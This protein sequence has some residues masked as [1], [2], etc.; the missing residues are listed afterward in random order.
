MDRAKKNMTLAVEQVF[1]LLNSASS[2]SV[3]GEKTWIC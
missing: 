2:D 3:C 1:R